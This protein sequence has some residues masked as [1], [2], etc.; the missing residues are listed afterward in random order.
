MA[1]DEEVRYSRE[2]EIP[3]DVG[4]AFGELTGMMADRCEITDRDGNKYEGLGNS[5][6]E[7]YRNAHSK[8]EEDLDEE[9]ED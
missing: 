7:A 5:R 6:D 2:S 8:L 9:D 1:R 4:N 3:F